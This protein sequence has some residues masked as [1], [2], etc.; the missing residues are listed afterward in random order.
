MS[1]LSMAKSQHLNP[2]LSFKCMALLLK[3]NVLTMTSDAQHCCKLVHIF[4]YSEVDVGVRLY[5]TSL[6]SQGLCT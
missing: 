3:V 4:M 2:C 6:E 5:L 1:C